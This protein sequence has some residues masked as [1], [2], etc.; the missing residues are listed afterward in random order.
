[1]KASHKHKVSH[2]LKFLYLCL[3]NMEKYL[4]TEI[5]TNSALNFKKK[6]NKLTNQQLF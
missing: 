4:I 6:L 1:M 2:S 5:M 3:L